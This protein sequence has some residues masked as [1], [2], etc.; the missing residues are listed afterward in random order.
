MQRQDPRRASTRGRCDARFAAVR[1]AFIENFR[2]LE[3]LGAAVHIRVDGRPVVDL[4]GGHR[5]AARSMPWEEDTLVNV[6]SVGKGVLATLTLTLVERGL[7]DLDLP[8][9][10]LWPEFAAAEK[11]GVT[12]RTLL[13]H[14]A[15]LPAARR[16]LPEGAMFD[17]SL[18]CGELAA[19]RPFW[20]PGTAH[21]YHVNTLGYLVGE[22]I[23]RAT[24][25]DVG[26][27]LAQWITGPLEADFFCGLPRSHLGRVAELVAP[28]PVPTGPEQ[29]AV[30][31]PPTGDAE[32]DL[33]VWH[34]Y[35][36]P[37]GLSGHGVVN[38]EAWRLAQIPSTNSHGTARAVAAIYDALL[39]GGPDGETWV[40]KD[41]L[42][43]AL[44]IHS[45]GDDIVLGRPSRFGL[46]F[47]LAQPSRPLGPNPEAFGH[48]G[49]G[50]SLGF[51]DPVAGVAFAY[52]TNRPWGV[53]WQAPRTQRL[54]DALYACLGGA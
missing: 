24:G 52:L 5:D 13:A 42:S 10:H 23:R 18:M 40:G 20:E 49:Y 9:A 50:G 7:L 44:R 47:Q 4:W 38:T 19:Q 43:E 11:G 32:H 25:R 1:E 15:G 34:T 29:W 8:V 6:Y 17:W 31:F 22:L 26:A 35:F 39:R 36:N 30:A 48:F 51:A 41:L 46:G 27:A 21:G 37:S 53:R 2:D 45:D 14:R 54:I 12:L 33:L 3:E 28:S 16:R